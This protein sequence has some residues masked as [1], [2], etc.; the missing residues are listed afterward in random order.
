MSEAIFLNRSSVLS[1]SAMAAA[2]VAAESAGAGEFDGTEVVESWPGAVR[3]ERQRQT[4]DKMSV[5]LMRWN[6]GG[7][8]RN[9]KVKGKEPGN[10][11]VGHLFDC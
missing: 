2:E 7:R 1:R 8:R 9:S 11:L 6:I 5:R 10:L 4:A 3:R